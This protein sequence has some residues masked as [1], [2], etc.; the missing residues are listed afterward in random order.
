MSERLRKKKCFL[1]KKRNSINKKK[2]KNKII[3]KKEGCRENS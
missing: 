2:A 1:P 3:R